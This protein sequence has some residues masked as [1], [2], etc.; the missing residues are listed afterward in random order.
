MPVLTALDLS[1]DFRNK[2]LF[3]E[4]TFG[5]DVILDPAIRA[6]LASH[7]VT[8]LMR[9]T[10]AN[11]CADTLSL[12]RFGD[13]V[14]CNDFNF[15]IAYFNNDTSVVST[16][17]ALYLAR[18]FMNNTSV[19]IA[20]PDYLSKLDG[21][22]TPSDQ[23]FADTAPYGPQVSLTMIGLPG[24]NGGWEFD[25][26]DSNITVAV[27]DQG[28]DYQR[29]DLGQGF[30]SGN[31]VEGGMDWPSGIA[32][33]IVNPPDGAQVWHGT[34]VA[35][36]IGAFTNWPSAGWPGTS[37]I[38][39]FIGKPNGIAGIAGG[40]GPYPTEADRRSIGVGL[41]GYNAHGRDIFN[42]SINVARSMLDA[43]NNSIYGLYGKGVDVI[44]L[45]GGDKIDLGDSSNTNL[46]YSLLVRSAVAESFF[47]ATS[48][49]A[50]RGNGDTEVQTYPSSHEPASEVISVGASARNEARYS[51]SHWGFNL[52][53]IAPSD[54][55]GG[56]STNLALGI[57]NDYG[58]SVGAG[59]A[60]GNNDQSI[61]VGET[62]GATPHVTGVVALLR[63]YLK[64][65]DTMAFAREDIEG[66]LKA[67]C[68]DLGD[69]SEDPL[70]PRTDPGPPIV[71][72]LPGYNNQVGYGF[73]R[74]DSIFNMLDPA[75]KH[76]YHL[77]HVEVPHTDLIIPGW[78]M[79][80]TFKS[81]IFYQP[82]NDTGAHPGVTNCDALRREITA[83][84]DYSTLGL[85]I[86]TNDPLAPVYVWGNTGLPDSLPV[87]RGLAGEVP[88]WKEPWCDVTSGITTGYRG[89]NNV[90]GI[91][92]IINNNG[93]KVSVH[94]YQFLLFK[95]GTDTVI[96]TIPR[97][98]NLG[99]GYT[100]FA[101]TKSSSGVKEENPPESFTVWPSIANTNVMA[102]LNGNETARSLELVDVVGLTIS[103][104]VFVPELHHLEFSVANLTSGMYFLRVMTD[105]GERDAKIIVKH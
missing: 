52:D 92:G 34:A 103:T 90:P 28:L 43:V 40:W 61:Y 53:L 32:A 82:T 91:A 42:S 54:A 102:T 26:G 46:P 74:A 68:L 80:D 22:N 93:T 3:S 17:T 64:N 13:T 96:D 18:K 50:A 38:G 57:N 1:K 73:L 48:F 35:S 51:G 77:F 94:T 15:M 75:G 66:M 14:R 76:A 39:C 55:G 8:Y 86:V 95:P 104:R 12:S 105:S 24:T 72:Y 10:A 87:K 62:S 85:P 88:N 27:I 31:K 44:N 81:Q 21:T 19:E 49:V 11:P 23:F 84:F 98:A 45:S 41:V 36:I 47:N 71:P 89:N 60:S 99:L 9:M 30:G 67:S 5:I 59:K 78:A 56:G 6:I 37:D 70:N 29:C 33:N 2:P 7:G 65:W 20:E 63:G 25:V 97:K 16:L 69:P 83:T 79:S 58:D 100:V 4:V 101:P